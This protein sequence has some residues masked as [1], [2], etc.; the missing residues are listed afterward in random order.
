MNG[1]VPGK[2]LRWQVK[3]GLTRDGEGPRV[4]KPSDG[5]VID[6]ENPGQQGTRQQAWVVKTLGRGVQPG[7]EQLREAK[8]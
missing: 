1:H 3:G 8:P 7:E 2:S 4:S 5:K 6:F